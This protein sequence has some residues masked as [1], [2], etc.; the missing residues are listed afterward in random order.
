[1]E[2]IRSQVHDLLRLMNKIDRHFR[3]RLFEALAKEPGFEMVRPAYAIVL[4]NLNPKGSRITDIAR[5]GGVTKQAV[6]QLVTQMVADGIVEV[7]A[8]PTDARAKLVRIPA[9]NRARHERVAKIAMGLAKEIEGK[10]GAEGVRDLH[11]LLK[12]LDD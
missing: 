11:R 1:M 5:R 9:A 6:G 12:K 7:V 2:P 8:D 10:L 4:R 3:E